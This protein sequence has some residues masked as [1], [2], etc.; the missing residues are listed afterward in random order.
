MTI[1]E[2]IK[3]LRIEAGYT[4]DELAKLIGYK[5]RATINKIETGER[6]ATQS[7]VV[8]FAQVFNT[9]PSVI[10]GWEERE[11]QDDRKPISRRQLKFALFGDP[12]EP[13]EVLD[14]VLKLAKLQKMLR[15][16]KEDE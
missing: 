16:K 1:G 15:E 14:D 11:P 12:D 3:K 4:Q 2:I 9:T 7:M 5:S 10:M 6:E 13:D 8:K